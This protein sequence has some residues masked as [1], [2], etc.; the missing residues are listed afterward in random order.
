MV[1]SHLSAPEAEQGPP[2]LPGGGGNH[3]Q[4]GL[5]LRGQR[6]LSAAV[7]AVALGRA[8]QAVWR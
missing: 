2:A 1:L 5:T 8:A 3:L 4:G 7:Q 6:G